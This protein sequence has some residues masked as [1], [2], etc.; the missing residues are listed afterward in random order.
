MKE[1]NIREGKKGEDMKRERRKESDK[2]K[3]GQKPKKIKNKQLLI[4]L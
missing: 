4:N 1:R 3:Q 2:K